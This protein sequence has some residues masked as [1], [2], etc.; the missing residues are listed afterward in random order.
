MGNFKYNSKE[1]KITLKRVGDEASDKPIPFSHVSHRKLRA[2][3]TSATTGGC[4]EPVGNQGSCGDCYAW[5]A[6]GIANERE[7]S[8]EPSRPRPSPIH[9]PP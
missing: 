3:S 5:A 4:R 7:V 8:Q 1:P 9:T 2:L 6:V